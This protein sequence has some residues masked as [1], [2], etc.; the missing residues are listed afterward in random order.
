MND[1]K[2]L[3]ILI[4]TDNML[5]E[6]ANLPASKTPYK[7]C[8]YYSAKGNSRHGPRIKI[9]HKCKDFK[10]GAILSFKSNGKTEWI[11]F[12]KIKLSRR[13]KQNY[14]LF[15]KDNIK[16]LLKYWRDN[17]VTMSAVDVEPFL[18]LPIIKGN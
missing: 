8:I 2:K 3:D 7:H 14:E 13:D 4:E 6:M 5:H 10:E 18:K 16:L 11:D 1:S 17:N 15:V 9:S 12:G